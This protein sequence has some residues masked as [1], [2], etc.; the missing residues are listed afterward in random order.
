[1]QHKCHKNS[2]TAEDVTKH[3]FD[4]IH[5][6]GLHQSCNMDFITRVHSWLTKQLAEAFWQLCAQT[7]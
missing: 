3:K 6:A 2:H 1:M 7:T 4:K 5:I